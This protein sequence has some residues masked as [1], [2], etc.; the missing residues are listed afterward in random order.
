MQSRVSVELMN[1]GSLSASCHFALS[2]RQSARRSKRFTPGV[3][4]I[5]IGSIADH[6]RFRLDR[7]SRIRLLTEIHFESCFTRY[8]CIDPAILFYAAYLDRMKTAD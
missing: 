8:A 2:W 5:A 1:T 4:G 7:F 6:W 3:G